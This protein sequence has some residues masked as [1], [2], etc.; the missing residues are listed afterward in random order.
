VFHYLFIIANL[1]RQPPIHTGLP[2]S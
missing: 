2:V 1:V